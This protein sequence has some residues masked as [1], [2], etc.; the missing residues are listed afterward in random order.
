MPVMLDPADYERWLDPGAKPDEVTVLLR[1]F[2][3][4]AMA[5]TRVGRRV[6]SAANDDPSL[7]E[8]IE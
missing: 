2:P 4:E 1:S 7:I 6:N 8:A 3:K 5:G